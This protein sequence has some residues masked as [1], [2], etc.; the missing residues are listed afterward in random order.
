MLVGLLAFHISYTLY[1]VLSLVCV[2]LSVVCSIFLIIIVMMQSSNSSGIGAL[3]GQSETFYGKNKSKT[4]ESKLKFLTIV[5]VILLAVLM[6]L[7]C[8]IQ[9]I[10]TKHIG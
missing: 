10:L 4:V 1:K 2:G 7:F 6:I 8:I 5:S 9:F 3:G